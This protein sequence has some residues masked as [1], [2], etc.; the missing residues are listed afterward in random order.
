MSAQLLEVEDNATQGKK[1]RTRQ[2]G[3]KRKKE[4]LCSRAAGLRVGRRGPHHLF[5]PD[6]CISDSCLP[7]VTSLALPPF[8]NS[9][10]CSI[11]LVHTFCPF[12]YLIP[13]KA[14]FFPSP[15]Q[16]PCLCFGS[17]LSLTWLVSSVISPPSLWGA[18]ITSRTCAWLQMGNIRE[19]SSSMVMIQ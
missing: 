8:L 10:V 5:S 6:V 4:K 13:T 7:F 12:S 1:S 18:E 16:F 14:W 15:P 2:T 17:L 3:Y 11:F 19:T 9:F